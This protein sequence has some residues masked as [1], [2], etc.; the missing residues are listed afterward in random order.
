MNRTVGV[1]ALRVWQ[2][3]RG[4]LCARILTKLDAADP[5]PPDVR[6]FSSVEDIDTV[7]AAWVRSYEA[8]VRATDSPS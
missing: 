6:Y 1:L 3:D 4:A 5:S 8:W 2:D 7:V